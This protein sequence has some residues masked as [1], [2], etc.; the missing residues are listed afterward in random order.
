MGSGSPFEKLRH[1]WLC[2]KGSENWA[3]EHL[4]LGVDWIPLQEFKGKKLNCGPERL[5]LVK[6]CP[7]LWQHYI[8][9]PCSAIIYLNSL[10]PEQHLRAAKWTAALA[11]STLHC[12]VGQLKLRQT[13]VWFNLFV[14]L[15]KPVEIIQDPGS[16]ADLQRKSPK[17]FPCERLADGPSPVAD[18][19]GTAWRVTGSSPGRGRKGWQAAAD[20]Q[21]LSARKM[22]CQ[23][24]LPVTCVTG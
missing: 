13:N 8:H 24:D 11:G 4:T 16:T 22:T 23:Q 1:S 7:V 17:L 20:T 5:K 21:M 2:Q 10:L 15:L 6:K 3:L 18:V 14:R 9:A 12:P 19:L